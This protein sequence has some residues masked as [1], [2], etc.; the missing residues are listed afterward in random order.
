MYVTNMTSYMT[1]GFWTNERGVEIQN[2]LVDALVG[3]A[4]EL[5]LVIS[6]DRS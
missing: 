3:R 6:G 5:H 4:P 1:S 2:S